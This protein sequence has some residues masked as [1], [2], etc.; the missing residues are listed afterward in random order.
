MILV[1]KFDIGQKVRVGPHFDA[2]VVC[3]VIGQ[4]TTYKVQ[5]LVDGH[6]CEYVAYDWEMEA[7]E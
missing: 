6:P 4:A 7:E 3:I 2:R 1:T 5:Y